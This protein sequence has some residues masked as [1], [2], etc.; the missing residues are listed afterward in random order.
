M[1]KKWQLQSVTKKKISQNTTEQNKEK[2]TDK[3]ILQ[4]KEHSY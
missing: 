4:C 1:Y 2:C 3:I